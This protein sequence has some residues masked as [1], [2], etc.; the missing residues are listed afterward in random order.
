MNDL[1]GRLPSRTNLD[2]SRGGQGVARSGPGGL[3]IEQ[4]DPRGGQGLPLY[5]RPDAIVAHTS[6]GTLSVALTSTSAVTT[7][8]IAKEF[9]WDRM[10]FGGAA[11]TFND[12]SLVA[13]TVQNDPLVSGEVCLDL[14]SQD[15]LH[16]PRFGRFVDVADPFTFQVRNY[17]AGA[18]V[19]QF[20]MSAALTK[21]PR[22]RN[23]RPRWNSEGVF[24]A[25]TGPG[26]SLV[27]F[28]PAAGAQNIAA[29]GTGAFTIQPA[30]PSFID[31][32]V[33]NRVT[34]LSQVTVTGLFVNAQP[35][36]PGANSTGPGSM[37]ACDSWANPCWSHFVTNRDT[38]TVNVTNNSAAT[39]RLL[40][41][42]TTL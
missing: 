2:R 14:F 21:H 20:A 8:T 17:N 1:T 25:S 5:R 15:S 40:P 22:D 33:L 30:E 42:I 23:L 11:A 19:V 12:L 39:V 10:V 24:V 34:N 35:V 31:K 13:L 7:V 29:A 18:L 32:L 27:A 38:V 16:S 41:T 28:G 9:Q 4:F 6:G 36:I 3:P 37:F 26:R